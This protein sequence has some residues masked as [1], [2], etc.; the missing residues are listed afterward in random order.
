M[1]DGQVRDG[2][3]TLADGRAV[4]YADLG[5]PEGRPC[6]F[7]H[8]IPGSRFQP[9]LIAAGARSQKL[10][11]IG[12][13]RPGYG[14]STF[15]RGRRLLDWPAD[16]AALTTCL[17]IERFAVVGM[18]GGAGYALACARTMPERVTIAAVLSGMGPLDDP[19]IGPMI[20]H[21]APSLRRGIPL[22]RR[23]PWLAHR[24]L[25]RQVAR[26]ARAPDPVASYAAVMSPADRALL[27]RPEIAAAV[28]KDW[29]ETF[30]QGPFGMAWDFLLYAL[31][32]GFALA[33]VRV[34]VFLW[35]GEDDWNVSV[36]FGRA[37]AGAL[38]NCR[39]GFWPGEG[40]LA[41]ITHSGEIMAVLGEA[42]GG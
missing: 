6:L 19:G 30:R 2:A 41:A 42:L 31:P 39:A 11:V 4:A 33:D 1:S 7:F 29:E 22:A 32:W 3:V 20:G 16:V 14:A 13:D 8:G 10:R 25:A 26:E 18:S 28:I 38:P 15:Q 23:A 17:G 37:V 5:D 12:I 40:H 21:L 24:L 36:A 9:E 34:P 27:A 35:H